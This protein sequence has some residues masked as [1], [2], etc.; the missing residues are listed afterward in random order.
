MLPATSHLDCATTKA[1]ARP[2]NICRRNGH[3]NHSRTRKRA[4]RR[5]RGARRRPRGV[6]HVLAMGP[7]DPVATGDTP[8][9]VA[10][11]SQ[12]DNIYGDPLAMP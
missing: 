10:R 5:L 4:R 6:H 11:E 8:E 2:A 12:L 7:D 9:P 1:G 3:D